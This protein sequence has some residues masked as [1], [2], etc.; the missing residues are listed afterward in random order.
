MRTSRILLIGLILA[1][2]A[3][4]AQYQWVDKDGRHVFS[5]RPPPADVPA[6]NVLTQ[7]KGARAPQATAAVGPSA[8]ASASEPA[9]A[10]AGAAA[11][12]P[13]AS[14]AGGVDKA[15][16]EKKKQNDAAEAARKKAEED[17][18]AAARAENCKRARSAKATLE[19]GMRMAR[20]NDKGEREVL[21]DAQR[22]TE[23][24]RVN[25]IIAS[26]CK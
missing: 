5:D 22:A 1:A 17:R 24:Q 20:V 21:D 26:D 23:L 11:A 14:A 3:A 13:A 6:K 2:A 19:S 18:V 16:E 12:R 7:P 25:A 9:S 4:H 10:A 8:S 15:L